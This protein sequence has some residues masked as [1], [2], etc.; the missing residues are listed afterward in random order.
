L[1]TKEI[2]DSRQKLLEN[3]NHH[4][5]ENLSMILSPR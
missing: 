3:L 5:V 2:K 1:K 4:I